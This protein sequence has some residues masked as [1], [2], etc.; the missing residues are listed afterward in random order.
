MQ[1]YGEWRRWNLQEEDPNQISINMKTYRKIYRWALYKYTHN[2]DHILSYNVT[3]NEYYT[4]AE[5]KERNINAFKSFN[6]YHRRFQ[7]SSSSLYHR[8]SRSLSSASTVFFIVGFYTNPPPT[9]QT[10]NFPSFPLFI[11]SIW[12]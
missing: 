1:I 4:I 12:H 2:I 8:L 7:S 6:H 11:W 3:I 5:C 10:V 9:L